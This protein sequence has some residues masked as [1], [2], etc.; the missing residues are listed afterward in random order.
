MKILTRRNKQTDLEK[1]Q[2]AINDID[3]YQKELFKKMT[4]KE[5]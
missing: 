3:S 4:G 1:M 5:I 2:K